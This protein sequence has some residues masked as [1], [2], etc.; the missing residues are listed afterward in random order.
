M[1][2][3]THKH[4]I[5]IRDFDRP[6][7]EGL[8]E[9]A[10][11]IKAGKDVGKPLQDRTIALLFSTASTRTRVSFQVG[12]R[13]LGG[14]G[15]Y[16][17][18]RD[19]QLSNHESINDTAAVLGRY[20][21]GLVV[22]NYDM[23][24]YGAGRAALLQLARSSRLPTINALDDKDHPCQAMADLMTLKERFGDELSQR[25]IVVTWA[26]ADRQKSPGVPHSLLSLAS[27]L[28]LN[29][30][31]AHPEGF[32]L[33]A[34]YTDFAVR[35]SKQSGASIE[36]SHDLASAC[37]GADA[38]YAKSWKALN[39]SSERDMEL[40]TRYRPEWMVQRKH[41]DV[42]NERAVFMNCMPLVR[43][44]QASAEIVDG[45]CSII[46]EQAANRLHAQKAILC[47]LF[48]GNSV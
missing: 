8:L 43:G 20:V 15:D 33:D 18:M 46:Y 34:E 32:E 6:Q 38:I 3:S 14:S 11:E 44:Q 48:A 21:D 24:N 29:I 4:F 39:L 35:H 47:K 45:E 10:S 37:K 1:I 36:F 28:G 27:I 7:I 2:G 31:L 25:K 9:L 16:F 42:A 41:F 23:A 26:Y 5:D 22:R 17:N 40:R 13:Q 30:T 12:I 19:L